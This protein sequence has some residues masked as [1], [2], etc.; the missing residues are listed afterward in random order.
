MWK[1]YV[2]V[3]RKRK[4]ERILLQS[5]VS[6]V[7]YLHYRIVLSRRHCGC[8]PSCF[9]RREIITRSIA[10]KHFH[11]HAGYQKQHPITSSGNW[12][13]RK[14]FSLWEKAERK[15]SIHGFVIGFISCHFLSDVSIHRY[16]QLSQFSA[17]SNG[18]ISTANDFSHTILR[19]LSSLSSAIPLVPRYRVQ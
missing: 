17:K 7:I 3:G 5:T 19:L 1:K 9:A 8:L 11:Y 10:T 12:G 18:H 13:G 4:T 15:E 14:S 6:V 16:I 2:K